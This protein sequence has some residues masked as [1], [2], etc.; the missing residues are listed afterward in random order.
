MRDKHLDYLSKVEIFE[1][2]SR[3]EL[4]QLGRLAEQIEIAEGKDLTKEGS[5][6]REFFVITKGQAGVYR[7]GRKVANLGPGKFF[8]ELS[9]IDG[10]PRNAT[11]T[12]DS[13]ME[14]IV[15]GQREFLGLLHDVPTMA[16]KVIKGMASRL[17]E[18][19]AKS[20]Q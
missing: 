8:G 1:A 7:K 14:V 9:L 10:G 2:F 12:A 6:G 11:V 19:D 17:R 5:T 18:S 3:K 20:I 13:N 16:M 4:A 15:L